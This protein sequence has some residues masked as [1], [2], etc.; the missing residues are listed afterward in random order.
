MLY[1]QVSVP[2]ASRQPTISNNYTRSVII[3]KVTFPTIRDWCQFISAELAF[4]KQL[5]WDINAYRFFLLVKSLDQ[6]FRDN[7]FMFYWVIFRNRNNL[8]KHLLNGRVE[9]E[10]IDSLLGICLRLGVDSSFL[11][12]EFFFPWIYL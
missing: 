5:P 6:I 3:E 4:Y 8:I 1:N 10:R 12:R 9:L 11:R 2:A 7:F